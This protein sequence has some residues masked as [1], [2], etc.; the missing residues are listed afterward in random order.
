V[1]H[2]RRV[3]GRTA[4]GAVRPRERAYGKGLVRQRKGSLSLPGG[5]GLPDT[6]EHEANISGRIEEQHEDAVV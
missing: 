3:R 6:Q 1:V 5:Q 4:T 2:E